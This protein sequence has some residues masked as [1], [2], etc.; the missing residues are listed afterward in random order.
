MACPQSRISMVQ[1][2]AAF[3]VARKIVFI[4]DLS[5]G[6]IRLFLIALRITLFKDSMALVV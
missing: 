4:A 3:S 1:R 5:S 6:K 2:L